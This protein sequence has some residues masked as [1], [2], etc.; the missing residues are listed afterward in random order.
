[1]KSLP[2]LSLL[3][4]YSKFSEIQVI[5]ATEQEIPQLKQ[6]EETLLFA[7]DTRIG[8]FYI[9]FFRIFLMVTITMSTIPVA[10][11]ITPPSTTTRKEVFAFPIVI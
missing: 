1:M 4:N 9:F 2:S 8:A 11:T 5:D 3:F 10:T 6:V 7:K